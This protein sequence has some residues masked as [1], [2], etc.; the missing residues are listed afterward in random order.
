MAA[1]KSNAKKKTTSKVTK[2]K[3]PKKAV[4]KSIQAK[5]SAKAKSAVKSGKKAVANLGKVK[6]AKKTT[7]VSGNSS[8][9]VAVK[10]G[11]GSSSK[12]MQTKGSIGAQVQPLQ[13]RLVVEVTP[14]ETKT[15]GGL[16]I[17]DTSV[18][19]G[20]RKGKVV[21]VGQGKANKKGNIRPLDVRL[22]D[23]VLFAE[24]SGEDVELNGRPC[25]ILRESDVLGVVE[26]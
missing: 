14:N 6:V 7:K 21:A 11:I 5:K 17:P 8:A 1:K 15:A 2:S 12:S 13:D 4:K 22:G 25:K 10:S 23:L 18:P 3:T 26:K 16:Y 24:Y 9:P 19:E 20:N